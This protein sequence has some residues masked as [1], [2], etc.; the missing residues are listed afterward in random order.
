MLSDLESLREIDMD[1]LFHSLWVGTPD[2][3]MYVYKSW[4]LYLCICLI[5]NIVNIQ[6][7]LLE[8]ITG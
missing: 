6:M 2:T 7:L 4:N 5:F 1:V 3:Q 8:C